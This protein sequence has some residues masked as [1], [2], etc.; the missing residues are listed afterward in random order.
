[1]HVQSEYDY[2]KLHIKFISEL[3]WYIQVIFIV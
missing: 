2:I 3:L 1:M